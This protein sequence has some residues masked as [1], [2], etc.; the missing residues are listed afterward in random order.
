[1]SERKTPRG[2]SRID[3]A[4]ATA[5]QINAAEDSLYAAPEDFLHLPWDGVE[6]LVGGIGRGNVWFV[7]GFSGNGK[8]TLLMNLTNEWLRDDLTVYYL[9][10]ETR[11]NELRTKLACL[12][13]GVYAGDVLSGALLGRDD[14][15]DTRARLVA[16]IK[17]QGTLAKGNRFL[18]CPVDRVDASDLTGAYHDAAIQMADVLIIDHIDHITHGGGKGGFEDARML[19]HLVLDLAQSTGVPTIVATQFNNE[20]LKGDRLGQYQPP[21]PHHVFMGGSKRQIA[22]GMLGLYRPIRDDLSADDLKSA[23]A[24]LIEPPQFLE[25]NCLGVTCMKNRNYGSRE[26]KRARL[27]F[28]HGVLRDQTERDRYA[29][30]YEATRKV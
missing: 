4:Y 9:G 16:D 14:W 12:R 19:A 3:A 11:P 10:T 7:G 6:G 24:G 30:S 1:M 21:Q 23:R 15:P 28:D 5:D 22:W 17:S 13:V 20:G 2:L 29:T 8:T 25:P 27:T 26:G 18:V